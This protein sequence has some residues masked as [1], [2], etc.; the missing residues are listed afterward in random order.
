VIIKPHESPARGGSKAPGFSAPARRTN[1]KLIFLWTGVGLVVAAGLTYGAIKLTHIA[2]GESAANSTLPTSTQN[3]TGPAVTPTT[4]AA[5]RPSGTAAGGGTAGAASYVLSAPATAGGYSRTAKVS[6][7][8]QEIGQG[9]ATELMTTVEAGGGKT[10][11]N[12]SAEYLIAGDQVLGYAGFN[13]S[14]SPQKVISDFRV[15]AT[16]V[17]PESAGPHGG[18]LACGQVT[19]TQPAS[20][21]GE[22]CVWATASTL[23]MVEFYGN[24]GGALETVTP[25]KAGADTLKFRD[26]VE[27]AKQ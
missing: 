16:G 22:A 15:G 13:G 26:G 11:G 24:S 14:F 20:T 3:V 10:T 2:R 1:R 17:T 21:T 9:G 25:A 27:G 19:V 8:V 5:A 23:G 12:V 7:T 4:T 6:P 18:Q